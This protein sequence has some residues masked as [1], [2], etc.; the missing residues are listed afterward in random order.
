M[1]FMLIGT[2]I[3]T[4]IGQNLLKKRYNK[5]GQEG[6]FFF[7]FLVALF[8]LLFFL[9]TT[10]DIS[11]TRVILPYSIGF[12]LTYA[13]CICGSVI[14]FRTGSLAITSLILSYAVLIPTLYGLLF[15]KEKATPVQILGIAFMLLSLYLLRA[16]SPSKETS[17]K[18]SIQWI[19]AVFIAFFTDGMCATIQSM[20][21]RVFNGTQNGNYMILSLII[22]TGFL[23]I[24]SLITERRHIKVL[25]KKSLFPALCGV[26]NG[27]TNYLVMII[28]ALVPVSIYFPVLAAGQLL[29]MFLIS[30]L[31][32]KEK[33]QTRQI[34]GLFV[35][36]L[37]LI[38]LNL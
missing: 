9:L 38:L 18:I 31:V 21:Q 23:G 13:T 27:A 36:L 1:K 25:W 34:L 4:C 3:F 19:L 26:F 15:L 33:F 6:P 29:L 28:I 37:S 22:C 8:A 35:G 24:L 14:A 17:K 32:Y 10:K 7:G 30:V 12:A 2:T 20:Q 16:N 5:D 11:L